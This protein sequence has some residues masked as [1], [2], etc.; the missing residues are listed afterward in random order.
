MVQ[1][2]SL[3]KRALEKSAGFVNVD[4]DLKKISAIFCGIHAMIYL[5]C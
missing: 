3:Q 4:Q 1:K 2:E 5:G